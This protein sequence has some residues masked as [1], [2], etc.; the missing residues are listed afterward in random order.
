[1]TA[2]PTELRKTILRRQWGFDCKCEICGASEERI[3]E[4]DM[5]VMFIMEA[6]ERILKGETDLRT[7]L[8]LASEVLELY[9][10]EGLVTPKAEFFLIAARAADGLGD[11]K[12]AYN[13]VQDAI[14]YWRILA[15]EDSDE[16]RDA[17]QFDLDLRRRYHPK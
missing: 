14:R 9:D 16:V 17:E 2:V 13:Y 3:D 6:K 12:A 4:S 11:Y 8:E 15:G 7:T 5:R 1:M 10:Q